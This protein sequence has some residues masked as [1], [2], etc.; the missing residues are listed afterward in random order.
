MAEN[1]DFNLNLSDLEPYI[2]GKKFT[3]NVKNVVRCNPDVLETFLTMLEEDPIAK[4]FFNVYDL[5]AD[6]YKTMVD[7]RNLI[8]KEQRDEVFYAAK[9]GK[10]YTQVPSFC[11]YILTKAWEQCDGIPNLLFKIVPA[12]A[13]KEFCKDGYFLGGLSLY[14]VVCNVCTDKYKP[15]S[16]YHPKNKVGNFTE[17]YVAETDMVAAL[18]N[19]I[20]DGLTEE[21]I[22]QIKVT[23]NGLAVDSILLRTMANHVGATNSIYDLRNVL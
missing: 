3:G 13:L 17:I 9:V 14:D 19:S 7:F 5:S 18:P 12:K 21:S 6:F 8:P 4:E 22:Q 23:P 15:L 2:L 11:V 1:N 20:A 10:A 16:F